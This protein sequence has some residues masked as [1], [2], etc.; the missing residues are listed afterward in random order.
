M[1][2]RTH[3]RRKYIGQPYTS[4][5]M[6]TRPRRKE[7][8]HNLY[9]AGTANPDYLK[10]AGALT[11]GQC[12]K[13]TRMNRKQISRLLADFIRFGLIEQYFEEHTF[14]FRLKDGE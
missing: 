12:S 13:L 10:T 1:G 4:E 3:Q 6:E 9:S 7:S 5:Y 8:N 11:L 2:L 14:Y